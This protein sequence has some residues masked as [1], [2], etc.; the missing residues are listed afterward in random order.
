MHQQYQQEEEA[1]RA[2]AHQHGTGE[3]PY[4][5]LPAK[6]AADQYSVAMASRGVAQANDKAMTS[7]ARQANTAD[8][9][10]TM[11]GK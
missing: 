5:G 8:V 3:I 9:T 6:V 4:Q 1:K 7:V 2:N 10:S 11:A